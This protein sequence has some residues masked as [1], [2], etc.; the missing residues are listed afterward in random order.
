MATILLPE[1]SL[2]A[3]GFF[4]VLAVLL[5]LDLIRMICDV[6]AWAAS[7]TLYA[8]V[9][10][11]VFVLALAIGI[12]A[13]STILEVTLNSNQGNPAETWFLPLLAGLTE[14]RHSAIGE[15]L[16][17]PLAP[18]VTTIAAE[19]FSTDVAIQAGIAAAIVATLGAVL[20]WLFDWGHRHRLAA[21]RSVYATAKKSATT[22]ADSI[23][24]PLRLP[25]VPHFA[26]MG[27]VAW[28]QTI[29]AAH[30]WGGLVVALVVPAVLACIPLTYPSEPVTAFLAVVAAICFYSF[31]LLPTALKFDFR[32][33]I[34]RMA[35]LRALPI[36]SWAVVVGQ[37]VCPVLVTCL[38]QAA[39]VAVACIVRPIDVSLAIGAMAVMLPM[40][41]LIFA[42]D[43]LLFLMYPYRP[44]QEGIGV[45]FR[46]TLIFTAKGMVFAI[47]LGLTAAWAMLAGSLAARWNATFP[48]VVDARLVIF[49]G[50]A[51]MLAGL[52]A[53]ATLLLI[54]VYRRFDVG[55]DV[56]G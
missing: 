48:L 9:R 13:T 47:A 36:N 10:A 50:N 31:L 18:F 35:V 53:T 24:S 29:G 44:T 3:L 11:V 21:E 6:V 15:V 4:G 55:Q 37:L 46:T 56:P 33:D 20:T 12:A 1:M 26:G 40:N 38:F 51:M 23:C 32:R 25:N 17:Y 14:A 28:R 2:P 30:Q 16:A 54:T 52:A 45:F 43:N 22:P 39:I 27:A 7:R 42:L 8:A 5:M 49:G 34:D 41:V 19:R